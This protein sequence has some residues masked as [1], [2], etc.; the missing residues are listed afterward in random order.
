[1]V[2]QLIYFFPRP[3]IEDEHI[4]KSIDSLQKLTGDKSLPK[5]AALSHN[6]SGV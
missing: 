4:N 1:M 6:M 3:E 2:K 5:G